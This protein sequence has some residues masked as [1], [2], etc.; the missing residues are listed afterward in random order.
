MPPW[1]LVVILAIVFTAVLATGQGLY[2]AWVARREREQEELLRRLGSGTGPAAT[3][4]TGE[5]ASLFREQAVDTVAGSLGSIGATMQET[6]RAADVNYGVSTLVTRM[7]IAAGIGAV[8][9]GVAIGPLGM[10]AGLPLA[11][12]PYFIVQ[13][14]ASSR[15]TL[16]VEQLPEALELMSRA[17]SAGVGLSDAFRLVA[18]EMT[19]PIAA[20]FGRIQEE[21]RFGRDYREAFDKML[22]RNPGVFDLRIFVSSVML[23]RDTGG[24]LIEILENIS[25]TIRARF[26]FDAKVRAMTSEARFSALILG[27]LPLGVLGILMVMSP[28]YLDPLWQTTQGNLVLLTCVVM[29][30]I[31]I[32]FMRE[33]SKVEV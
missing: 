33:M 8:L 27:C 15:L 13:Q 2:W 14:Q 4:D 12:I 22:Q 21:V 25:D 11:Y 32:F 5:I 6:L 20:E 9:G 18:E 30:A 28:D 1:L 3:D 23:Q 19:M 29:Y 17:L 16:L 7:M 10:L 26:L 24:N 31:G